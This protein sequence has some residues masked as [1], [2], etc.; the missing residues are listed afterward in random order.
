MAKKHQQRP[1]K[2][3]AGRNKPGKSTE[4]T[5]G[6]PKKQET[7]HV[8]AAEHENT[9][10]TAQDEHAPISRDRSMGMTHK[11]DSRFREQEKEGR[12]HKSTIKARRSQSSEEYDRDLRVSRQSGGLDAS[13][14]EGYAYSA[15]DIKVLYGKLG[16]LT[17]DEMKNVMV[18]PT[19]TRLEQGARYIDL[20]HLE[21]GEFVGTSDMMAEPENYYVP[22]KQTD[23]VL[24]N[25]LNQ[26]DNPARLDE[27]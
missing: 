20:N 14:P 12:G 4:I 10:K 5:T 6:T 9:G 2:E 26:V 15:Y 17:D 3:A 18:L 22:K 24:W 1:A 16:D 13:T 25:R 11:A 27:S 23:Y 21:R 19:G 7:Y 8:Q